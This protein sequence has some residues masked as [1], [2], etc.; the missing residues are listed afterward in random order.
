MDREQ[1]SI[2]GFSPAKLAEIPPALQSVADQGDL[3]GFVTLVWRN[4]DRQTQH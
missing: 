3:S 4:G 2:A 1:T